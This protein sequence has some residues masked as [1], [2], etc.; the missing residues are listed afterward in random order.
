M[1]DRFQIYF[2]CSG[3]HNV[4]CSVAPNYVSIG[5]LDFDN[6]GPIPTHGI[7]CI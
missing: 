4:K 5:C 2:V 7:N 6:L 3:M 1:S